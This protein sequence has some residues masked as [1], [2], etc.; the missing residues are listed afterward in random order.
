MAAEDYSQNLGNEK[1]LHKTH[2]QGGLRSTLY[3][4]S[5]D[6]EYYQFKPGVWKKK[7]KRDEDRLTTV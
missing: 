2:F 4:F 7:E 5:K 3:D 6:P 1:K